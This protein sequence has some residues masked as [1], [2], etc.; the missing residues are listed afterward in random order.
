MISEIDPLPKNRCARDARNSADHVGERLDDDLLLALERVDDQPDLAALQA[1]DDDHDL[2]RVALTAQFEEFGDAHQRH[3][4]AAQRDHFVAVHRAHVGHLYALRLDDRIER[5]RV[6]F[7]DHADQQ[8]LNDRQRERQ[9]DRETRALPGRGVDVEDAFESEMLRLT[10]S[11]P[12]PRPMTSETTSAV[13]KPGRK[14]QF[15]DLAVAKADRPPKSVP[16]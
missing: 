5:N 16:A 3:D 11:M 8:R 1:H 7:F 9:F 6:E 14:D 13:E 12:T 10:T 4:L 15:D 2:V